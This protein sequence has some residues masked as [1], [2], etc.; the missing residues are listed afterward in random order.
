MASSTDHKRDWFWA[1][2]A[3]IEALLNNLGLHRLRDQVAARTLDLVLI[4]APDRLVGNY[5]HQVLL[6][7]QLEQHGCQVQFLD[8][9]MSHDPH[10]LFR[11]RV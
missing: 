5:V 1:R 9:P 10:D 4:T 11:R 8:R 2:L 7:E 6:L 3:G